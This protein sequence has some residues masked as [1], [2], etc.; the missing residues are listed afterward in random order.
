[1]LN[2][3]NIKLC[4]ICKHKM[5]VNDELWYWGGMTD[6]LCHSECYFNFKKELN[7]PVEPAIS[8]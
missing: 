4:G 3:S 6:V 1:M 5:T 8:E 2:A 7:K